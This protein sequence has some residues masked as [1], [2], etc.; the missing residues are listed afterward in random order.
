MKFNTGIF[1]VL[2]LGRNYPRHQ[3]RLGAGLLESSSVEKDLGVLR[4]SELSM[5]QQ[6]ARVAK[7]ANGILGCSRKSIASRSRKVILPLYSTLL[8]HIQSCAQFWDPRDKRNM[9]LLEQVESRAAKG[10]KHLSYEERLRDLDLFSLKKRQLRDDLINIYKYLKGG[11]PEDEA[12]LFPVVPS[13]STSVSGHKLKHRKFYMN[14][15]K[16]L[17]P[18]RM[19]EHWIRLL[20]EVKSS[21]S[22]E[23][24]K[25]HL[26]VILC[27]L[28]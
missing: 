7:K 15:R 18:L 22:L 14:K 8:R 16:N 27:N 28:L 25:T 20:R 17:F 13:N 26:D 9:E 5:S 21:P 19:T 6:C 1:R 2:H 12:R 11:C 4:D 3:H 24:F 10:L 23:M